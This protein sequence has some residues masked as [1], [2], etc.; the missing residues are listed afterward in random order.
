MRIAF[1]TPEL[2]PFS[3]TGGLADVSRALAAALARQGVEVTVFTPFHRSVLEYCEQHELLWQESVLPEMLWIGDELHPAAFRALEQDGVRIV[4]VCNSAFFDRPHPYL[5]EDER[6]YADNIQRFAFFCRAVLEYCI[7]DGV[8]PDVF[9][10]HDWQSALIPVYLKTTYNRGC[11]A[12]AHTLFTVHN[13]GYQGLFEADQLHATGLGWGVFTQEAL[14]Y[15]GRLNLLKGGI[16]FADAVNAVSPSY[17]KE[18]QTAE[19]GKGLH[20]VLVAHRHKLSGILNGVDSE[21]WNPA[22][23]RHLPAPYSARALSG[24]AKCKRELQRTLGLPQRPDALLLGVVSRFD[25]QKG[26][27]LVSQAFPMVATL[28]VQLA[29]LGDGDDGLEAGVQALA[30]AFPQQ[31]AVRLGYDEALAH[32][33]EAGADAFLMPSAYEPCGLNQMYS[34]LYGTA[35]IVRETGG[36]KDTVANAT[37]NRLAEGTA[38]GFTFRQYDAAKL[39]DTI[40]RAARMFHNARETWRALIKSMMKLDYSW[41]HSA[42]AY[43]KLYGQLAPER[44]TARGGGGD[45]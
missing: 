43:V 42:R 23:D 41:E 11:L 13:L 30:A 1:I 27:E 45:G 44:Q 21:V 14:E 29:I 39:A 34:Q 5:D 17:A 9:H 28:D 18:I 4:F 35:P 22:T 6:D 20:G 25:A 26:I 7:A 37:A 24:K 8:A 19:Y 40:R 15:F 31:V 33:I 36:L 32:L 12:G 16:V 10:A 2:Y 38:S 3:K